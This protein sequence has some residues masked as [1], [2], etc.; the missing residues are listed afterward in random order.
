MNRLIESSLAPQTAALYNRVWD[1]CCRFCADFDLGTPCPLSVSSLSL[2]VAHLF[3][4]K[5]SPK[6]ISTYLS[7]IAY[8]HK[9]QHMP[10]PTKDFVI[11]KMVAGAYR[12]RPSID[13]RLPITAPILHR[14][15]SAAQTTLTGLGKVMF[16][17]MFAFAFH[18]YARIGELTC[19]TRSNL[20]NVLKIS[21]IHVI[22]QNKSPVEI[23]VCFRNFKHNLTGT[24]HYVSFRV[25]S[26]A[27]C[28]VKLF[29]KYLHVRGPAP[30]TLFCDAAQKPI[31]RSLFDSRLRLCLLFCKLD[32]KAYKGHSF[33]IGAASW[34]A[35]RGVPDSQ[36]RLRGRWRSDA[37]RKYIRVATN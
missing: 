1:S 4:Y 22:T 9:M 18:T 16:P 19:N 7:A 34:D 28:P 13:M 24:P 36:I 25:T 2:Y 26:G 33:R 20:K 17:A 12:L 10:D 31:M 23:K 5:L 27:F 15:I 35:Q 11:Q 32:S 30:G 37:F 21:E 29:L 8:F 14:L 3:N 6:T